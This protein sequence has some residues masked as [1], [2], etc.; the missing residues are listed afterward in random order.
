MDILNSK[1]ESLQLWLS[2]AVKDE[3]KSRWIIR[4]ITAHGWMGY[5]KQP[6]TNAEAVIT[7]KSFWLEPVLGFDQRIISNLLLVKQEFDRQ[8]L[9]EDFSWLDEMNPRICSWAWAYAHQKLI[10]IK[11]IDDQLTQYYSYT[12]SS[13]TDCK[14]A[15]IELLDNCD[16][17]V[18]QK[19]IFI[20]QMKSE[21]S[22]SV[23]PK[24]NYKWIDS[25]NEEQC[26]WLWGSILKLGVQVPTF[27]PMTTKDQYNA[28][29][30]IFDSWPFYLTKNTYCAKPVEPAESVEPVEPAESV[31]PVEPAESVEP[32]EPAESVEPVEPAESVE[33]VEPAEPLEP[34]METNVVVTL[35]SRDEIIERLYKAWKQKNYRKKENSSDKRS[36]KLSTKSFKIALKEAE[37][38][39]TTL[40]KYI[41]SLFEA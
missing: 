2:E 5:I 41:N 16:M 25:N 37:L 36:I 22:Y 17:A 23:F 3:R 13:H 14:L 39:N 28:I 18:E 38:S 19:L 40:E 12:P 21:W 9:A 7:L 34:L 20:E 1:L 30:A 11:S 33:P 35:G 26:R 6:L 27:R 32:V 29:I 15:A 4:A 31:E 24:D 10:N 8:F